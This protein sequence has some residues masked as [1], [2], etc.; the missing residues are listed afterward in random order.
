MFATDVLRATR[1]P[2]GSTCAGTALHS[3]GKRP[4]ALVDLTLDTAT[5]ASGP[6]NAATAADPIRWGPD[7]SPGPGESIHTAMAHRPSQAL[8]STQATHLSIAS[9]PPSVLHTESTP[10]KSATPWASK[11]S[12]SS[13]F[14]DLERS[15]IDGDATCSMPTSEGFTSRARIKRHSAVF[16]IEMVS[17][18]RPQ[19]RN[20]CM[21]PCVV[22]SPAAHS[23]C[24][25]SAAA[26]TQ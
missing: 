18:S 7:S 2:V 16:A 5:D 19:V 17:S 11:S 10:S 4:S 21:R 26:S 20:S 9:L 8:L 14:K 15:R 23:M 12:I 6:I 3:V 24:L 25:S 13:L 22:I 1:R